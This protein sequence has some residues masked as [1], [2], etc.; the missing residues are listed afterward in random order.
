MKKVRMLVAVVAMVLLAAGYL[1]SQFSYFQG[2]ASE[3][4][5]KVDT[6]PVVMLSLIVFLVALVL[7]FIPDREETEP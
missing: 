7:F 4:A 6:Q 5:A 2:T 3:Y 1:A